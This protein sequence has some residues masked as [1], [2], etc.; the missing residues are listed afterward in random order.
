MTLA[1]VCAW[2]LCFAVGWGISLAAH[3]LMPYGFDQRWRPDRTHEYSHDRLQ[4][5]LR[6][7]ARLVVSDT[8]T[9]GAERAGLHLRLPVLLPSDGEDALIIRVR[10]SGIPVDW[11]RE[12]AT[13]LIGDLE[14]QLADSLR[15]D[16]ASN[17]EV[18]RVR[19]LSSALTSVG[20]A[21]TLRWTAGLRTSN[22]G[23]FRID[24]WECYA[25]GAGDS[26]RCASR[27]RVMSGSAECS[28]G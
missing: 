7:P 2:A 16:Y 26:R 5:G 17:H 15:R 4:F 6:H 22:D 3:A 8:T 24:Q 25:Q 23:V 9:A 20:G 21:P 27:V 13:E 19:P 14:R 1:M 18:T 11:G 12:Q 28:L 10:D